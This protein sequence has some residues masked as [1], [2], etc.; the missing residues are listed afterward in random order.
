MTCR[1]SKL[2]LG[3]PQMWIFHVV[4]QFGMDFVKLRDGGAFEGLLI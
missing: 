3:R 1:V 4:F 2:A